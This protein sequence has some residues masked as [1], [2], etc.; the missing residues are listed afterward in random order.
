MKQDLRKL[1]QDCQK[2][3]K[4]NQSKAN[5]I[6]MIE[7]S[8]QKSSVEM[9]IAE[10]QAEHARL[11]ESI[12]NMQSVLDATKNRAVPFVNKSGNCYLSLSLLLFYN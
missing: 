2:L 3:L 4:E 10:V 8:L 12:N 7:N 5:R 9:P 1:E 6:R 11:T